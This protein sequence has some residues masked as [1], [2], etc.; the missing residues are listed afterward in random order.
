MADLAAPAAP[1]TSF[2][3]LMALE[4]WVQENQFIS[5][6]PAFT[7]GN[8]ISYGGHVYAQAVWA[9]SLGVPD[10]MVVHVSFFLGRGFLFFTRVFYSCC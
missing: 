10:G 5:L 6:R 2:V 7:G 3:D 8:D 4:H 9:A 1:P